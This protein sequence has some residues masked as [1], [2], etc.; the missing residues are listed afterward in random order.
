M[1]QTSALLFAVAIS[2]ISFMTSCQKAVQAPLYNMP[3]TVQIAASIHG[4]VIDEN[5]TPVAGAMVTSETVTALTDESGKFLI[6]DV[7]LYQQS[8]EVKVEK[9]GYLLASGSFVVNEG[10]SDKVLIR[11]T[12]KTGGKNSAGAVIMHKSND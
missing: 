6:T 9:D 4:T 2:A 11:L 7:D 12:I 1:K 10:V 8:G 3:A 5:E